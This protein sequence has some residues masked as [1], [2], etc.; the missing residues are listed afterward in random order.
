[1]GK[2]AKISFP[3]LG[4]Q[5]EN[6]N[7]NKKKKKLT[8]SVKN[9]YV[10]NSPKHSKKEAVIKSA[11]ENTKKESSFDNEVIPTCDTVENYDCGGNCNCSSVNSIENTSEEVA[12]AVVVDANI[13]EPKEKF[14]DVIT[15][16]NVSIG[17]VSVVSAIALITAIFNLKK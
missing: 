5:L 15:S 3:T 17:F 8:L 11:S 10:K 6:N 2:K 14:I 13:T 12:T 1:M 16:K 9:N 4:T 7:N